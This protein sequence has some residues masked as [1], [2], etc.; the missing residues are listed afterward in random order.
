M[1][2]HLF[3]QFL[4]CLVVISSASLSL[5]ANAAEA[6]AYLKPYG[7]LL[8]DYVTAGQKQG[9]NVALVNYEAW[10][11]DARHVE[12]MSALQAV[13]PNGLTGADKIAYWINAYNLLTIDLIVTTGETESI[14]NQGSLFKNVWKS[15]SWTIN[16]TDYTLDQIE[17]A[18]LRHVDEPRIHMAINCASLSCPDLLNQPYTPAQLEQQLQQQTQIFIEDPTKGVVIE[19]QAM[20]V[21]KIFKWFAEDFGGK[22]GTQTFIADYLPAAQGLEIDT[23]LDYNWALNSQN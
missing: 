1:L 16:G 2:S 6:D 15:H 23:Y 7:G 3:K 21:S 13:N 4:L 22:S 17:H 12:A 11:Q 20:E 10:G 9:I 18:I 19:G 14:R 8:N 5:V